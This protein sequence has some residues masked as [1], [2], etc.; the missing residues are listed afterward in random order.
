[1]KIVFVTNWYSENMGYSENILPKAMAHLGHEVHVISSTAQV[2]Y[3]GKF[4][5]QTYQPFLGPPIVGSGSK[6]IG[7]HVLHRL[8]FR[9]S[10][11]IVI[12]G[13]AQKIEAL[14]PDIVQ[15]FDI[16]QNVYVLAKAQPKISYRLFTE[17]H[18]H[19]SV[20]PNF[21]NR[22]LLTRLKWYWQLG[23]F[24]KVI[25]ERTVLCYPIAE[26]CAEI[27][28]VIYH[29]PDEKIVI[30][31]LGTDTQ[32]FRP[33]AS[34]EDF[35]DREKLRK[36]L[37]F[38]P[39][40]IVCM[41]TG[42]ITSDKGPSIL[43]QAMANLHARG[44]TTF[45]AL[46]M[47]IGEREEM[48]SIRRISGCT[49][50]DFVPAMELPRYYRATDIAVWPLQE[51]TSQLDAIS[52]GLPL[53]VNDTVTV[54]QRVEGNGLFYK[55]GDAND[56]ADQILKLKLADVRQQLGLRGVKNALENFSWI[57]L[58]HERVA[59]YQRALNRPSTI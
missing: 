8:P 45:K 2:Y 27:A 35:A 5:S 28:R 14:R 32:L 37:G 44:E 47:G 23:R 9:D 18:L 12:E 7:N 24:L 38:S 15:T 39:S 55:M 50:R 33:P 41:Y 16:D 59:D 36:S 53:I 13:L 20:F 51:S 48:D 22:S 31:S 3:S 58:A 29:V 34:P 19:A 1:M 10:Y 17:M 30:Q 21:R 54:R 11:G 43:A 46:F 25:N 6:N 4:Y 57:K 52:C 40:D 42:R 26:D 56:L 49:I